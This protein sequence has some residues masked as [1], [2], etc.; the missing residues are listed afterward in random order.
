MS[1]KSR[2]H[3]NEIACT[4]DQH[5]CGALLQGA[6]GL[7][8]RSTSG[9][10]EVDLVRMQLPVVLL[11]ERG[12]GEPGNHGKEDDKW[13]GGEVLGGK[14]KPRKRESTKEMGEVGSSRGKWWVSGKLGEK[15]ELQLASYCS[16]GHQTRVTARGKDM[17]TRHEEGKNRTRLG[18]NPR[19]VSLS[20]P[21]C[22]IAPSL[23]EQL[24]LHS[25]H[26]K[27]WAH[28]CEAKPGHVLHKCTLLW[29]K[30]C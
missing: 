5:N 28:C 22:R 7:W 12:S 21:S 9:L 15:G 20:G 13:T 18:G 17:R 25:L 1:A 24:L 19:C 27:H 4:K 6:P 8:R 14:W 30:V 10:K 26:C 16:L 3:V 11:W 23:W 2:P 29:S